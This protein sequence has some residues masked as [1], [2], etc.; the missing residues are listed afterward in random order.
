MWQV[1]T[2][3]VISAICMVAYTRTV[4]EFK[5]TKSDCGTVTPIHVV[6][7]PSQ[8]DIDNNN[9]CMYIKREISSFIPVSNSTVLNST[10]MP[11]KI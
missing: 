8:E 11:W 6:V 5:P 4:S 2:Y 9:G 1:Q 7:N 3:L 10:A